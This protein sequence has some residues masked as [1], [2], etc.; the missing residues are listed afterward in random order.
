[1]AKMQSYFAPF[2]FVALEV[3]GS[4]LKVEDYFTQRDIRGAKMQSYFAP[5][6]FAAC[7][8]SRLCVKS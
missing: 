5:F 2:F 3:H 6:F 7:F 8:S 4:M 1:M